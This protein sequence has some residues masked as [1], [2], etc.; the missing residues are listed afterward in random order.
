MSPEEVDL[1]KTLERQV[2]FYMLVRDE[3]SL[4]RTTSCTSQGKSQRAATI[5]TQGPTYAK[6]FID[7][8]RKLQKV[9]TVQA[10]LVGI[11]NMLAGMHVPYTSGHS[12]DV[13]FCHLQDPSNLPLFHNLSQQSDAKS[14]DPY[15]PLIK[16][17][18]LQDEFV[19][20]EALRIMG[21]LIS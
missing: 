1:L 2:T 9:D 5:A 3:L 15:G 16:C 17:L 11:S 18:S 4:I 8:L 12:P 10:V 21:V 20:L 7:L 19:L 13:P 6:L 14:D